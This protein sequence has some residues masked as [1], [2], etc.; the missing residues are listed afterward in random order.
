MR[1]LSAIYSQRSFSKYP[2][3]QIV[4]E[5]E[6]ILAERL[7]LRILAPGEVH[8]I[9]H[10][11]F[12]NNGL[13]GLYNALLPASDLKLHF[14]MEA[15]DRRQC[16]YNKNTI[17]VI[18][19]FWLD[20]SRLPGFY[21]AF[22]NVPLMLVTSREVY[23]FLLAHNCPI[24]VEHWALSYPDQYAFRE[25]CL[26]NKKY[27]FVF[28]GRPNPFFVRYVERYA[29]E[30][31]DFVY[32]LN[33]GNIDDRKYF[34]N[35]GNVVATDCGRQSYLDM[36]RSARIT[37]YSTP[38]IDESKSITNA[39]N[40]VTPRVFEFLCNGCKVIGH[41]SDNP[42]TRWYNLS[43]VVPNVD[44]YK[45]FETV[46]DAMRTGS[47]ESPS[48]SAFMQKH[49]TSVRANELIQILRRHMIELAI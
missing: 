48:V 40:Q 36:I 43:S 26:E 34:D 15:E 7:G 37:C 27:D 47:F 10:R 25:S 42:D 5:W 13:V 31:K 6:D 49:Y 18:I 9:I 32:I 44:T 39:F 17:P 29:S 1:K 20:E 41:Y 21:D 33:N 11:R 38:G 4:Y 19:D 2:S 16:N 28:F 22:K 30:H 46:L 24:P 12:E 35:E 3:F 14:I 45:E 8:N 23:E